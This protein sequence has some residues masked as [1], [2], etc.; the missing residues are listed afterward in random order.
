MKHM[1]TFG[2][3]L[4]VAL[5]ASIVS[6][7]TIAQESHDHQNEHEKH[8]GHDEH[9]DSEKHEDHDDDEHNHDH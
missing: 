1:K 2:L 8:E 4:A 9:D 5:F 7:T 6:V 3:F